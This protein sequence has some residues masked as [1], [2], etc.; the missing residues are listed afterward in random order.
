MQL[1][2]QSFLKVHS[3]EVLFAAYLTEVKRLML[4]GLP[5]FRYRNAALATLCQEVQERGQWIPQCP[6]TARPLLL[7]FR[8]LTLQSILQN[9]K[10]DSDNDDTSHHQVG[11]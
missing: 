11:I 6:E 9:P 10:I 2:G 5:L 3:E 1:C 7:A 8:L 4:L